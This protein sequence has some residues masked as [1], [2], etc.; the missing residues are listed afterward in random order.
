MDPYTIVKQPK[1]K[2]FTLALSLFTLILTTNCSKDK[3]KLAPNTPNESVSQEPAAATPQPTEGG[4]PSTAEV[5]ENLKNLYF[6]KQDR[7]NARATSVTEYVDFANEIALTIIPDKAA[8]TFAAAPF[9]IHPVGNAWVHVKENNGENYKPAFRSDYK[10][11]HLMF[12]HFNACLVGDGTLGKPSGKS[13]LSINPVKENR[14]LHTHDGNQWIKVYAYDYTNPQR[15][16]DLLSINVLNGPIQL[17]YKKQNG[18]WYHWSSLGNGKINT[19]A[20][21]V[22][23]TEV[24][25]SSTNNATSIG[26]DNLEIRMPYN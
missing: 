23:I 17:W 21:A 18:T 11:Y 15:V 13:C 6:P 22:G 26:F 9:Y 19:S 2:L 12:Q 10:H 8:N 20:H 14:T 3:D 16:F 5:N 7:P 1:Y 4:S 24:L 25:I